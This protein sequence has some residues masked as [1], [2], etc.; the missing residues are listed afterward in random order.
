LWQ[1]EGERGDEV[2]GKGL[3][4]F[5]YM[6]EIEWWNHLS[7]YCKWDEEGVVEGETEEEI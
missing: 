7:G 3:V 5:M 6:K 1:G 4:G 2:E